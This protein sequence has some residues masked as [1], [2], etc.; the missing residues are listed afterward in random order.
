M[1]T[2]LTMTSDGSKFMWDGNDF[3]THEEAVAA[4]ESYRNNNFEVRIVRQENNF[5]VYS[6]RVIKEAVPAS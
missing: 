5:S 4:A 6:R 3:A 2:K 1:N